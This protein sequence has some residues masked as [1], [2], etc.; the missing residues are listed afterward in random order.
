M[1][2]QGPPGPDSSLVGKI[3]SLRKLQQDRL[4]FFTWLSKEYGDVVSVE[5]LGKRSVFVYHPDYIDQILVSNQRNY[6]RNKGIKIKRRVL[7]NGLLSSEGAY[8]MQQRRCIQP[9]FHSGCVADM[10]EEIVKLTTHHIEHWK[11]GKHYDVFQEMTALNR[12]ILLKVL[13]GAD[14]NTDAA[15][16]AQAF[17]Y[18]SDYYNRLLTS[19]SQLLLDS[20][21]PIFHREREKQIGVLEEEVEWLIT[22]N[23]ENP[24]DRTAFFS[25]L[26]NTVHESIE[27]PYQTM[28]SVRDEVMTMMVAGETIAT[29]LTWS[30]YLVLRNQQIFEKFSEELEIVLRG[31]QICSKDLKSLQYTRMIVAE[32]LRLYPPVY[33]QR[34][35]A[36]NDDRF[37][38]YYVPAN[39]TVF[40]SQWVMHRDERFWNR[41][42]SVVPERFAPGE[43]DEAKY[44]FVYIPF[45]RGIHQCI[46]EHLAWTIVISILVT[47]FQHFSA[48]LDSPHDV[49]V[50]PAI[51]L[52]PA[53]PILATVFRN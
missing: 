11:S 8:H 6:A 32:A 24:W 22:N 52:R 28:E 43:F 36:I 21:P 10:V 15:R 35:I 39:S 41:P 26:M 53:S 18:L 33:A 5:F 12:R 25:M 47:I 23:N 14:S 13:F 49:E 37:G 44:R 45:G 20:L 19:P 51:L 16:L 3:L 30:V 48:D 7:G 17:S 2:P 34:R 29:A 42:D 50:D 27:L 38:D 46:G 9:A 1:N 31:R 40:F 4:H